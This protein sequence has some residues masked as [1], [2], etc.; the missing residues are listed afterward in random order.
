MSRTVN[1]F[2]IR[3][4]RTEQ[5]FFVDNAFVDQY[6]PIIGPYGHAVY[7][8]IVRHA[9]PD[10]R[11]S[12]PSHAT[13]AKKAGCSP[14]KVKNVLKQFEELGLV[15]VRARYNAKTGGQTSNEYIILDPPPLADTPAT[16]DTPGGYTA[17]T[18]AQVSGKAT[19]NPP[20]YESSVMNPPKNPVSEKRKPDILDAMVLYGTREEP[21]NW[22]VPAAA[23]GADD[24][25]VAVEAFAELT[26]IDPGLL[27]SKERREWS[28]VLERVG[29][30]RKVGPAVV[31]EVIRKVPESEDNWRTF[32]KPHELEE[33]LKKLVGQHLNGGIRTKQRKNGGGSI[34]RHDRNAEIIERARQKYRQAPPVETDALEAE[35]TIL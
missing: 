9:K 2:P 32:S 16:T 5:R 30:A 8:V 27:T 6:G 7:N 26:G 19:K 13:I 14:A 18:P 1:G 15:A 3:D 21:V 34:A 20:V 22:S 23:G 4:Q 28:R 35:Y 10:G 11:D 31:V 25:A 12:W 17:D 33:V 24:W 29:A